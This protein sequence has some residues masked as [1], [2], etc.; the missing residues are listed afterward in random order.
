MLI[1][2]LHNGRL[3]SDV[4]TR[5]A[6]TP[7]VKYSAGRPPQTQSSPLTFLRSNG[8]VAQMLSSPA[9]AKEHDGLLLGDTM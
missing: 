5:E 8:V 9:Y 1:F 2:P 7:S 4:K 6:L 3:G